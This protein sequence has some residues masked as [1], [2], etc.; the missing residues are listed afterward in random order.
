MRTALVVLTL[1]AVGAAWW[2]ARG[3]HRPGSA[4]WRAVDRD[5]A[6]RFADVP[7]VTTAALADALRGPD[8]PLLLDARTPGEYAVSHLPGACRVDP[9]A[10][11]AELLSGLD[12]D[13]RRRDVVVYCSVGVRSAGVARRLRGQGVAAVNLEGSVFRWA[14]EGR[15]L[16]RDGRAAETVH[17]YDAVWGR[18]L[19][20]DRRAEAGSPHLRDPAE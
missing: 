20:P 10:T 13:D 4:A 8:P 1:V 9:D 11:A 19:D 5:L 12:G 16:V 2:I 14:N 3:A 18:L 7:S 15:A 6:A 17:P